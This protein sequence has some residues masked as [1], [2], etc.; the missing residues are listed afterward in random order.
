MPLDVCGVDTGKPSGAAS[1]RDSELSRYEFYK[2]QYFSEVD[3]KGQNIVKA[4][5]ESGVVLRVRECLG[6]GA[7][8]HVVCRVSLVLR[9]WYVWGGRGCV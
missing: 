4:S 9:C 7:H 6:L 5:E 8:E 2:L 3:I 1:S